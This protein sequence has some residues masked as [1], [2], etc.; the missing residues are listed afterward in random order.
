ESLAIAYDCLK[1][2]L[3][4][5]LKVRKNLE[6]ALENGLESTDPK[7]FKLAA[8]VKLSR[9]LKNLL[10]IN[11][12]TEIDMSYITCAEYQLFIDEKRP[13]GEN[14]QP[15]H[16]TSDRFQPGEANQPITGV[17]ASDAIA[18][19]EWLTARSNTLGDIYEESGNLVFAGQ[20]R[21]RIP[22]IAEAEEHPINED[23]IGC[24]CGAKAEISVV[25]MSKEQRQ[26]WK[27]KISESIEQDCKR[28][29]AIDRTFDFAFNNTRISAQSLD[30]MFSLEIPVDD[31]SKFRISID[32]VNALNSEYSLDEIHGISDNLRDAFDRVRELNLDLSVLHPFKF[33]AAIDQVCTTAEA[34]STL[35]N[36]YYNRSFDFQQDITSIRTHLLMVQFVWEMLITVCKN[37]ASEPRF[38]LSKKL[39]RETSK[40]L[41]QQYSIE[42]S[43]ALGFYVFCAVTDERRARQLPAWEGIR[44]VRDRLPY[45]WS[46]MR[47]T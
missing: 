23:A 16:W 14:R 21:L 15:D 44:I 9:R 18:F 4:V 42:V 2:G 13:L 22:T 7:I 24:W 27:K 34:L 28:V 11:D 36:D 37:A 10:R 20:F 38:A 19:C 1:E 43:K 35:I 31:D 8:E 40:R 26:I 25:G 32:W 45:R 47:M 33:E 12:Q 6:T 39:T 17:R 46:V 5:D 30:N 41:I 3:R 29:L